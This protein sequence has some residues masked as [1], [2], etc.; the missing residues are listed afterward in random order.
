MVT[1]ALYGLLASSGFVVG[2]AIGLFTSPPRRLVASIIAFG[3]G[4]LV[5]A[6]TFELM[7]EAF[8]TG[9]VLYTVGG[10]LLGA[11]IYSQRKTNPL[12]LVIISS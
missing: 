4:I 8:E 11:I 1:A 6:L 5:V 7:Q 10:F 12:D 3:S 9:S 2:V